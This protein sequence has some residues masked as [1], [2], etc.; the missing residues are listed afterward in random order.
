MSPSVRF[1]GFAIPTVPADMVDVGNPNGPGSVAGTYRA[2]ASNDSDIA[3]RADIIHAAVDRAFAQIPNNDP[4]VLNV[5]VAPEFYWHGT[6]GPYA[7]APGE[8]D[9]ITTIF[10]ALTSRLTADKYPNTLFILGTAI[11]TQVEDLDEVL[12]NPEI[13]IRNE[14]VKTIGEAWRH[15]TGAQKAKVFSLLETFIE[16]AHANPKLEVRN[17]ALII[18]TAQ[19]HSIGGNNFTNTAVTTEK[20]FA[21]NEDFLLWDVTDKSVVTEQTVS[22]PVLDL[23]RGD[24]KESA[25]DVKSIFDVAENTVGVE[26]CLDHSDQRLRKSAFSSPWPSGHNAIALHLI[27]SCGMQLHPASVAARSGGIAFNCDGQ[28]ALSPSDY[29]TAHAGTVGGV[30]SLHVDYSTDGDTPYQA[31]TQLSRIVNGPI[32]GDSAAASSSNATFEVPDT[33]VT[34][35]PLEETSALSTVFAGGAGA[36]H[37]YGLTKPLSL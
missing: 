3:A 11:S 32:G 17:R 2:L 4:S 16:F 22:Y 35:I 21:S 27:P 29:G 26:I 33:D 13:V 14:L 23:S 36:L 6:Q 34:I 31:H 12:S 8:T 37:I 10:D 15:S 30:A 18:S 28:Y 1:I 7:F 25:T 20:Y 24:I 9:P 5:F 19:A